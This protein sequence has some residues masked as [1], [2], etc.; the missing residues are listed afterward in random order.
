MT[1]DGYLRA[2]GHPMGSRDYEEHLYVNTQNL[3]N[4]EASMDARGG[5]RS[6]SPKK[7]IFDMSKSTTNDCIMIMYVWW[8]R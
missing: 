8:I 4:M 3:D 1:S 6:E 5:R 2:D 7:D